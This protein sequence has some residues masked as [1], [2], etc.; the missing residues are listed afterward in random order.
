MKSALPAE[1]LTASTRAHHLVAQ[2]LV[3]TDSPFKEYL[4]ATDYCTAVMLYTESAADRKYFAHWRAAFAAL[5]VSD[6]TAR[7]RLL[8]RLRLDFKQDRSPLRSLEMT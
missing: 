7:M 3:P 5:M 4:R 8:K 2:F 1:P 6:G